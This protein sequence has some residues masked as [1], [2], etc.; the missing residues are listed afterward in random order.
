M[1]PILHLGPLAIQTS[2]LLILVGLWVG[3]VLAEHHA[4]YFD[5]SGNKVYNLGLVALISGVLGARLGYIVQHPSAFQASP[6]GVISPNP[7]LLDAWGG[8]ALA[9]LASLIYLQRSHLSIWSA[10]DAMT[11][12][13]AV[14]ATAIGLANL[15]NG[16]AFGIPSQVPW[17]IYLWGENRQPTQVYEILSGLVVLG[18][19]W[20]RGSSGLG[21]WRRIPL[22]AGL[23]FTLFLAMS[24]GARLFLEAFRGDST[25]IF[26]RFRLAMLVAWCILAISLFLIHTR[27]TAVQTS[28]MEGNGADMRR[29]S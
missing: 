17:S 18:L 1:F 10:L 8:F 11:S 2:G 19:T 22:P 24:A 3:L 15:A 13:F 12:C 9:G 25:L 20:P 26:G 23:R 4:T 6:L 16:S 7:L 28:I 21:L 5:I 14:L 27:L 29:F